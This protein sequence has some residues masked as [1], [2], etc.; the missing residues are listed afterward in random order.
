MR[1][2]HT[3]TDSTLDKYMDLFFSYVGGQKGQRIGL[4]NSN[5]HPYQ[6]ITSPTLNLNHYTNL[7]PKA[8][9]IA[10]QGLITKQCFI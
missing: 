10:L 1:I 5:P 2:I 6:D 7:T 8:S 9:I 4:T 3:E